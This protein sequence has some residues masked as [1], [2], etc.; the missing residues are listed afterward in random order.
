MPGCSDYYSA[1]VVCENKISS[2]PKPSKIFNFWASQ[3]DFL[4]VVAVSWNSFMEENPMV[5]FLGKL[6]RLK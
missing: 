1:K 5:R 2:P 6:K 4:K 3:A